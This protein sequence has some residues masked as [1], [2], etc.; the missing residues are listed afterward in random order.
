[1]NNYYYSFNIEILSNVNFFIQFLL[2][3]NKWKQ[4]SLNSTSLRKKRSF[5]WS[6]K[7]KICLLS[8]KRNFQFILVGRRCESFPFCLRCHDVVMLKLFDQKSLNLTYHNLC[9]LQGFLST[10]YSG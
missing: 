1:M 9:T 10:F 7:S 4:E 2:D 6:L 5:S 3:M 8:C